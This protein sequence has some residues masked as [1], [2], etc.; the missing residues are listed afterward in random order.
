MLDVFGSRYGTC[1]GV[2]R[3][4]V[5]RVGVLGM[6]GL[7][8]PD[9]FR[10]RAR[11]A[12]AGQPV[13]NTAVIQIFL[14]GGPSHIDTYDLKPDA[15]KEFR[16]VFSPIETN[17]NGINISE[18]MPAQARV[19]DRMA[20]VR[21]LH[22]ATADHASGTHWIMTGFPTT[23]PQQRHNERPSVGSVVA[24]HRQTGTRGIPPYVTLPGTPGYSQA[25]YLGPGSNPF[26]VDGDSRGNFRVRNLDPAGG[27]DLD[28]I[29]ERRYLLGQLDTI[30]RARDTSGLMDGLDEFTTKA[31]E[32]VTGPTARR[33]FDLEREDPRLR[34][35]YGRTRIG[36]G[37]LLA[38]R[39]VEAGV[40]FITISDGGWDNHGQ[41][42]RSFR[43]QV[44]PLDQAIAALVSDLHDR[45]LSDRVL[46]VVWG[47]F[48]RTPR[49]NG[50]AG[51]TTGRGP[52]RRSSRGA[53]CAWARSSVRP[54]ARES[55]RASARSG[56]RT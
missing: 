56:P 48:G 30:E 42:E 7:A 16:G 53:V 20:I 43:R 49:V 24:R 3:R 36:Q 27:L 32:M 21:S 40:S 10:L 29:A 12:S 34:D 35:R 44:P 22:H 47:E 55:N 31:Y 37:C 50:G 45:G 39:L 6:A 8:L 17:V 41:L 25:A 1:D 33:A 2:S 54:P 51:A 11:A 14:G 38:R 18:L 5:L 52:C 13:Q 9:L 4:Q 46:L 26:R 28:R 19:M 23:M 15:P